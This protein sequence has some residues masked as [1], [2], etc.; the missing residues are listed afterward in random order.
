[1]SS[2]VFTFIWLTEGDEVGY[3]WKPSVRHIAST[4]LAGGEQRD[5]DVRYAIYTWAEVSAS[6][7]QGYLVVMRDVVSVCEKKLSLRRTLEEIFV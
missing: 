1:M 6:D 3:V 5:S 4:T 2:G 7:I